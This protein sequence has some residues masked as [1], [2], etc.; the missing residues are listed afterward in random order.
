MKNRNNEHVDDVV[1]QENATPSPQNIITVV[2]DPGSDKCNQTARGGGYKIEPRRCES[3]S[4]RAQ[5]FYEI[6]RS[7]NGAS[8]IRP[9][10][11]ARGGKCG[12]KWHKVQLLLELLSSYGPSFFS[13]QLKGDLPGRSSCLAGFL[14]AALDDMGVIEPVPGQK[15]WCP[16]RPRLYRIVRQSQQKA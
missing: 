10:P 4:G 5:V 9:K 3:V 12:G 16:H 11:H 14:I 15:P 6:A 2:R 7:Q 13:E 1:S 8:A